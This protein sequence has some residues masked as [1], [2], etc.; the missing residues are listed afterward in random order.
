LKRVVRVDF[1][2]DPMKLR[3]ADT[4]EAC[5]EQVRDLISANG[6]WTEASITSIEGLTESQVQG[7]WVCRSCDS[8]FEYMAQGQT[9]RLHKRWCEKPSLYMRTKEE[10]LDQAK[11]NIEEVYHTLACQKQ[12]ESGKCICMTVSTDA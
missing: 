4:D 11:V 9:K 3:M 2:I 1:V 10:I 7:E 12:W 5:L 6:F 8:V